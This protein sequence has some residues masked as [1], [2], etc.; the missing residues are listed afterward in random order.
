MS[1]FESIQEV[2]V[3]KNMFRGIFN[4]IG[5]PV[6]GHHNIVVWV[7]GNIFHKGLGHRFASGL[8]K[9]GRGGTF[10]PGSV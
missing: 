1:R 8:S 9:I 4:E 10:Y 7:S 5:D 3:T 2:A 6:K